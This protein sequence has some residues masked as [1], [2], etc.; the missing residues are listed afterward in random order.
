MALWDEYLG[1]GIGRE[2]LNDVVCDGDD[3]LDDQ[4]PTVDWVSEKSDFWSNAR[5]SKTGHGRT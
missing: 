1:V 3:P 4:F 2:R 5:K